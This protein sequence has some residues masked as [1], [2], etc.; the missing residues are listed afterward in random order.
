MIFKQEAPH[1]HFALFLLNCVADPAL[2]TETKF[3]YKQ[4]AE[5]VLLFKAAYLPRDVIYFGSQ[6]AKKHSLTCHVFLLSPLLKANDL[7][8]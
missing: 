4:F 6:R 3:C 5:M 8:K 7:E 1:V 2:R